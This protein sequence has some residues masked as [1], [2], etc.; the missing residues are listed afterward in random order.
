MWM[1][2]IP[3]M[4]ET[5]QMVDPLSFEWMLL[6]NAR[7]DLEEY[8]LGATHPRHKRPLKI[9][10]SGKM[11]FRHLMIGHRHSAQRIT[12]QLD[13]HAGALKGRRRFSLFS[14]SPVNTEPLDKVDWHGN[15]VLDGVNG[16]AA[17]MLIQYRKH[18]VGQVPALGAARQKPRKAIWISREDAGTR[19]VLNAAR[20]KAILEE[21]GFE[22]QTL[23][24]ERTGQEETHLAFRTASLIVGPHDA[25]F[26]NAMIASPRS[27]VMELHPWGYQ[28]WVRRSAGLR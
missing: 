23:A 3:W 22:V 24:L 13:Q 7:E 11:C 10:G 16:T 19:R 20:L 15:K 4:A 21:S 26:A 25:G 12:Q 17:N 27:V 1:K 18:L 14:S 5:D 28:E 9:P 2:E 6:T 8:W